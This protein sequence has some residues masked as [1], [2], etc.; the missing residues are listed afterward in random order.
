MPTS[1]QHL[2]DGHMAAPARLSAS[3]ARPLA[4]WSKLRAWRD[5]VV[6]SDPGQG[7]LRAATQMALSLGVA[8]AAAY[9]FAQLAHPYWIS[10]P[11]RPHVSPSLLAKL[12]GQHNKATLITLVLVATA[13]FFA[14]P[15]GLD[16]RRRGQA[17]TCAGFPV[18]IS[19]GGALGIWLASH[20]A[21]GLVVFALVCGAG[22]YARRFV[23]WLGTRAALWGTLLLPGYVTG[24][25]AGKAIPLYEF[26]WFIAIVSLA[27]AVGLAL[28]LAVY[29]PLA[30]TRLPYLRRSLRAR[31]R[32][33]LETA[34][35]LAQAR[36]HEESE[37]QARRLDRRL[38]RLNETALL[39][40]GQLADPRSRIE[41][42]A[43]QALHERMFD[44]EIVLQNIGSTAAAL[45]SVR[46]H[47]PV[48]AQAAGWLSDLRAG[49][50]QAAASW[51]ERDSHEPAGPAVD[52]RRDD[53][54]RRL[55]E[56]CVAWE[57]L[58]NSPP[59][60]VAPAPAGQRLKDMYASPI[61]LIGGN[62]A[63][64]SRASAAAESAGASRLATRLHLDA[65]A[66]AAIRVTLAVGA[67]AAVG[68][69]ISERRYYWAVI[70]VFVIYLGTNT[71]GEQLV[72]A[73]RRVIGTLVGILL[74]SLLAHAVGPTA[75][76][77]AVIIPALA[78]VAYFR[79]VSYALAT[80]AVTITVSQLYV[81]LGEYSNHLL[82]ARLAITAVGAV[83]AAAVAVLVFPVPTRSALSRAAAAFLAALGELLER[84]RDTVAGRA[85]VQSLTV[86]SRKLDDTLAQMLAT[87]QPLTR[88]PFRRGQIESNV[89]LYERA[90]HYARNLVAATRAVPALEP[91]DQEQLT[92]ALD[93]E[94]QRVGS[95]AAN[96][97]GRGG[98][99]SLPEPIQYPEYPIDL[100][101]DSRDGGND[102]RTRQ[103]RALSRLAGTL[104]Q[105]DANL[106]RPAE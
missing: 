96:I 17:L 85:P 70:A 71:V 78:L 38:A 93:G 43:A 100:A 18:A 76:S 83:I 16:G 91:A 68:S 65:A 80:V 81:Q 3:I 30:A 28:Q 50:A 53:L 103:W 104:S 48:R 67:A 26:Y 25:I 94:L 22:V 42:D 90:A 86:E 87:A 1:P 47:E 88:G 55:A 77:L 2:S 9:G 98:S 84:V 101:D 82:L 89:A 32:S 95:L 72:K 33:V 39:T 63:G 21:V 27:A 37:R 20:H 79:Q 31:S 24:F 10:A 34:A 5:D 15:G 54:L 49:Q 12:H 59:L 56:L 44:L 7:H 11:T 62:L 106:S 60:A 4:I 66:Q 51:L 6:A 13:T 102:P 52:Q 99:G 46:V 29:N 14:Q 58:N 61:V 73:S 64:S 45:A 41:A 8:L 40:D 75:W 35:S 74:G 23:P 19:A 97:P 69:A 36:D 57:Q 92:A 105:L